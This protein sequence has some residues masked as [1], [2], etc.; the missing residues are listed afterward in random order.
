MGV[1]L[2]QRVRAYWKERILRKKGTYYLQNHPSRAQYMSSCAG[3]RAA[4]G[5]MR[6]IYKRYTLLLYNRTF[7]FIAVSSEKHIAYKKRKMFIYKENRNF[8]R[9]GNFFAFY[10]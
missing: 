8:G 3:A 10:A 5:T 9:V 1:F 2:S 7:R 6:Y 4:G